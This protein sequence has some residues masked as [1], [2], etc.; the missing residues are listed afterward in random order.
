ME[1]F[2]IQPIRLRIISNYYKIFNCFPFSSGLLLGGNGTPLEPCR[3]APYVAVPR[4]GAPRSAQTSTAPVHLSSL[5]PPPHPAHSASAA[6]APF[7]SALLSAAAHQ[8]N[9]TLYCTS[10]ALRLNPRN[11]YCSP[12]GRSVANIA[13]NLFQI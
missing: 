10:Y 12:L 3:V 11:V 8:V 9:I 7:D 13:Y 2:S 6:F 1:L 4:L 5:P